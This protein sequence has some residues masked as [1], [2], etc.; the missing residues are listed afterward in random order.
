MRA[1]ERATT[2]LHG[3]IDYDLEEDEMNQ[4]DAGAGP[5]VGIVRNPFRYGDEETARDPR[6]YRGKFIEFACDPQSK[7]SQAVA[8]HG[9]EIFRVD[10]TTYDILDPE[11][12]RELDMLMD[13]G[14]RECGNTPSRQ[15]CGWWISTGAW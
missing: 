11:S 6:K 13:E 1:N 14:R 3:E 7:L 12:M 4:R 5:A 9:I 15:I 8:A 10:K 2:F